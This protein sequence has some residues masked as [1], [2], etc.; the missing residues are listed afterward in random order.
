MSPGPNGAGLHPAGRR[1]DAPVMR[2]PHPLG[3][4]LPAVYAE[5][6]L[7]QRL[8]DAFDTV[9]APLISTLDNF[10]AYIDPMLA[11]ADFLDWLAGWVGVILDENWP[12]QRQRD[13]VARFAALHSRR[14]TAGALAEEV[15]LYTMVAPEIVE[16]GGVSWSVTPDGPLPGR[17]EPALTIRLRGVD[18]TTVEP[19]RVEAI[20]AAA[21][22]AHVPHAVEVLR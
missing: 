21:K 8:T 12:I 2:T 22:P 19:G 3:Q 14:G 6:E 1:R 20:V 9:L 7:I 5:D 15:A 13:F 10:P 16:S 4:T 11:P 17:P 18:A